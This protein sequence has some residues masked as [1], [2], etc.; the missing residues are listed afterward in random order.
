MAECLILRHSFSNFFIKKHLS[1]LD[2]LHFSSQGGEIVPYFFISTMMMEKIEYDTMNQLQAFCCFL[3]SILI[4]F[5]FS[6]SKLNEAGIYQKWMNTAVYGFKGA[7]QRRALAS[8]HDAQISNFLGPILI[9]FSFIPLTIILFFVENII[10][11]CTKRKLRLYRQA[12]RR[13]L[14]V[15]SLKARICMQ[16]IKDFVN[17]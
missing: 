6:I 13:Q 16:L 11:R 5:F 12:L 1:G 17:N 9:Y 2:R 8:Y 7:K 4:F 10:I 14:F 15:L 3:Q